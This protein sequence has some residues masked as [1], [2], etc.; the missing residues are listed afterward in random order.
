MNK[1]DLKPHAIVEIVDKIDPDVMDMSP[2]I[3][4]VGEVLRRGTRDGDP[5]FADTF[6]IGFCDGTK[7]MFWP[8][9]I[10]LP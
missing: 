5:T 3:G 8:E 6:I 4:R 10:A 9:E 1:E 7:E 2:F